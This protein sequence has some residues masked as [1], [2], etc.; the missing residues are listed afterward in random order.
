MPNEVCK[1]AHKGGG[2][3]GYNDGYEKWNEYDKKNNLIH[4]KYSYG[5]EYWYEYD[6]KNNLIHVKNSDGIEWSIEIS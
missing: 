6:K 3:G 4:V 1:Q 2:S 5:I